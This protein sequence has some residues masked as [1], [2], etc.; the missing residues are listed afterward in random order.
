MIKILIFLFLFNTL[1]ALTLSNKEKEFIQKHPVILLGAD[2][3]WFP[4]ISI[5]SMGDIE[6]IDKEILDT[7]NEITGANFQIKV[8][9]W[10]N[11]LKDA[12]EK[13]IDGLSTSAVHK[14]RK[15]YFN[16]SIPYISHDVNLLVKHGNPLGIKSLK[17]LE[18][19]TIVLQKGNLFNKKLLQNT[20]A[21]VI[22]KN[23][24]KEKLE[25][26]VYGQADATI[27]AESND[28][29][30]NKQGLPYL[31]KA[32]KFKKKLHLVFSVR[33][34][35]PEVVSILNKAIQSIPY[36]KKLDIQKRWF[37][38][39]QKKKQSIHLT[40][41]EK[42]YILKKKYIKICA[43]P[44]WSLFNYED[45]KSHLLTTAFTQKFLGKLKLKEDFIYTDNWS[46]SLRF[47]DEKKC[48]L[49]A[50]IQKTEQRTKYINFTK[51]YT[52]YPLMLITHKNSPY[53][54]NLKLLKDKKIAILSNHASAQKIQKKYKN[55]KIVYVNNDIEGLNKVKNKEV[56]AYIEVL[57][58]FISKFNDVNDIKINR[59]LDIK[60][61]FSVGIRNDDKIL[62]NLINKSLNSIDEIEKKEILDNL[63]I[64]LYKKGFDYSFIIELF[65]FAI[66]IILLI[67][68]WNIRLEREV[69]KGIIKSREQESLIHYYS[70]QDAMKNLVCNISHQW[71]QPVNELSSIIFFI[72]TKLHLKQKLT[73]KEIKENAIKARKIT[74][75]LSETVSVFSNFYNNNS[76]HDVYIS[77]LIKQSI[78]MSEGAFQENKIK[79]NLDMKDKNLEIK[80]KD[81]QQVIISIFNNISNIVLERKIKEPLVTI[82][83]F[84]EKNSS[85]LEIEDNCGGI[86]NNDSNIFDFCKSFTKNGTGLGLYISKRIIEDKYKGNIS[87][88]NT[89]KGVLFKIILPLI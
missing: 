72:E 46:E 70:K 40:K 57:P 65:F 6:G 69:T 52:S 73:E 4:Y 45:K 33:K 20:K 85:I 26:T 10:H 16:F 32:F 89:K 63:I 1:H 12:K 62:F 13:N 35:W 9:N 53:L 28:F 39:V 29:L 5:N 61:D 37:N 78:F 71:K 79:V 82:R 83:L 18:G 41:E 25:E 42:E 36:E 87:A 14:E 48:D 66:F 51:S 7:I 30:I 86:Q 56:F 55:I 58:R 59:E 68:Y 2:K 38:Q 67:I 76:T 75:Y 74:D 49:I 31:N 80:G 11:I 84:K 3:S 27:S 81:L 24:V 21:T 22:Y 88:Q 17:D 64:L 8:G 23:T 44:T 15:K 34:D 77:S 50:V 60:V 54:H 19:K 47:I 43:D